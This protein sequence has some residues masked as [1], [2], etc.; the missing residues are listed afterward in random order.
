VKKEIQI[1]FQKSKYLL[2]NIFK[3]LISMN[4]IH[5]WKELIFKIKMTE[6]EYKF[7]L[8]EKSRRVNV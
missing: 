1:S 4:D 3:I 2:L 6:D 7:L 5:E 8:K